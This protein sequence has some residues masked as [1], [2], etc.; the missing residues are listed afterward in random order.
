MLCQKNFCITWE[1]I[2]CTAHAS[3][4]FEKYSTT[5]SHTCNCLVLLVTVPQCQFPILRRA[6]LVVAIVSRMEKFC[7][8]AVLLKV[9]ASSHYM[10]GITN[11]CW[12]VES[13]AECLHY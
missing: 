12:L 5:T 2:L 9:I 8:V 4:H 13:L 7:V 11:C 1:V 3:T 6:K 10:F